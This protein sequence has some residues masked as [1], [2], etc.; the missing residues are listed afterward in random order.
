MATTMT[1]VPVGA[2]LLVLLVSL[3]A[4]STARSGPDDV[5]KLPSQASR[6]FRPAQDDDDS[7]AG[8][9]W[10]V[11]VAGSSGYWN[12]RHQADICHAYQLLRKGGLKEEN[13]VVFMY[14]DIANNY[15][16]PRPGTL[17]NSPHGKDVYQGVPKD[18]T[19]D[20]VN[21][22]NLFAVILGDKTAVKGGSGK[23]VDSG[24]NDH[25]FIFYSDHGGPGVLG[26]PTS[27]YLYANDLNDVLK[28]KHASGTYKSL[29]FY[30]EACESGSIFE[31]LLPEGL[32]IYATTA[33]NAEESSWG[34]YCPGEEP[35]PP[36]EY[37]TCLGDLYSVAW[38][39]DSGMHN[40]Q[41][42]T[43]HQQYEL[44]K[45]RTAPVG[46]SYGS[47]VMQYGDV[48]LSKDN[49]DLYM[50]TNPA[51]DNFT[52]AD[53]NSLKPPSRVTNQRDADLVHFW[54]KYRKAPEGSARK[55]EA[56]K[57]VL[58]AMSHR[59]HVDNSVILV[60][61]ILFGISE[62]P[63]VL[64]KVRSAGQP[65]VDDWN[66][67]KNLVRAFERHCGSLSQY[68]IKHMRS[69]ANICNAGI[70]T[71]QMEEA[72]SQACTSIPP[73]PW[74]SLHRGFSA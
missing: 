17:I 47:H 52:F 54:E 74:S 28:K 50:G 41:T 37:E 29:V 63:E 1:R 53:A 49:L 12:Y 65:L 10:A 71:E 48:G 36:P 43:L 62:G 23:V 64:N 3:V 16:N 72:A 31:G 34:T 13:I 18:Y 32:N 67:L 60:G 70:R 51:N 6:F 59:L 38:M 20:D 19:G 8:T 2:F 25:I 56:Q 57:Q 73:G 21:V 44:V 69:F 14:D 42:E 7:N 4:V 33:S 24:P 11:L 27:P 9:R 68:G 66:C 40:L 26:M 15:E 39:E 45:R 58:E 55:T 46:Y 22:D 61:K 5:I 30:L 35:S